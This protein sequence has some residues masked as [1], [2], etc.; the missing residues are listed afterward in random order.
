MQ[1]HAIGQA[2]GMTIGMMLVTALAVC[3]TLGGTGAVVVATGDPAKDVAAV[4]SAVDAGGSVALRG[5]FDFGDQGRVT[6][7]RDVEIVGRDGATIRGGFF[8]LLSPVPATLPPAG[9]G[10]RIVIRDLTFTGASWAPIGIGYASALVVSGNRVSGLRPHPMPLPNTP[11]GLTQ[12]VDEGAL[13][14]RP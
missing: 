4:Q 14:R 11:V 8:T 1:T 6:L 3:Q 13:D 10:P 5:T 7:S 9:P 12:A 2:R